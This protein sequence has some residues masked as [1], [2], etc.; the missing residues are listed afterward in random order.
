MLDELGKAFAP[1]NSFD[2]LAKVGALR[3]DPRNAN[4]GTSLD[5][6]AHLVGTQVDNA[7]APPISRH[8][9]ESLVRKHLGIESMPGLMDDPAD[10]MFTEVMVFT[11]GP[12]VVFPG[13]IDGNVDTLRWLLEAVLWLDSSPSLN[14]FRDRVM[15]TAILCL[16]VSD[17]IVHKAGLARGMAPAN[18][19]KGDIIVPMGKDLRRRSEAVVFSRSD[20]IR[21]LP[22]QRSLNAIIEPLTVD[23]GSVEWDAYSFDF[24]VL[25]HTPFV[26]AGD[27]Y[28]VPNASGVIS[29]LRHR[30]LCI[31]RDYNVLEDLTKTYH[32]VV[33]REVTRLLGY[34]RWF[35][36]NL[37]LPQPSQDAFSEAVFSLDSDKIVYVQLVT[38]NVK[39]LHGQ[40]DPSGWDT[41]QTNKDM[42]L[43]N[44]DVL[45]HFADLGF[46]KDRVLTLCLVESLGR[47]Y[48]VGYDSPHDDSLLMVMSVNALKAITLLD[49]D[50]QL[51]LW[52]F[53]RSRRQIRE[54]AHV[55]ALS[56]LDEYACYRSNDHSYY[57]SDDRRPNLINVVSGQGFDIRRRVAERF[58]FHGV[59]APDGTHLTEVWSR[60]GDTIP[61]YHLPP[62]SGNQLAL[63][64]EGELPV[65]VWVVGAE[66]TDE[67][68]RSVLV[69]L[70]NAVAYWVWQFDSVLE[71]CISALV[72]D[73]QNFIV[74]L[75]LDASSQWLEKMQDPLAEPL[76]SGP[77]IVSCARTAT[78][79]RL[80]VHSSLLVRSIV[81]GNEGERQLIKEMIGALQELIGF[82]RPDTWDPLCQSDIDKAIDAIAPL[83]PKQMFLATDDAILN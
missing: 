53:A 29:G 50:D 20:L 32:L 5:A 14:S 39:D 76:R 68:L 58:D 71:P 16:S 42:E 54:T 78:G 43:R 37:P 15:C 66:Q 8:K 18:E 49:P 44:A 69:T 27:N 6:L 24:G 12:Y 41:T 34:W 38:D 22:G 17:N 74:A 46:G 7:S 11:G 77:V 35:P 63:V 57:M 75:D 36:A 4:R 9:L 1:Y 30:V 25:D 83:G 33:Q 72:V 67:R 51:T 79:V 2:L 21:A 48:V 45:Q 81:Q 10:Q 47:S 13:L 64:V 52:K 23:I 3:I 56:P 61:I 65:P 62:S 28:V 31:A 70:V 55:I 59:L 60:Y 80:A 73:R 82:E 26:R 40:Y 19:G